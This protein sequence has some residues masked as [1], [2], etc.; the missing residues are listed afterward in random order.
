MGLNLSFTFILAALAPI[1]AITSATLS[2][3]T[4]VDLTQNE[5]A[6]REEDENPSLEN[7]GN[8]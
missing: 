2:M 8:Q 5:Y 4:V 3:H 1:L 7:E 6:V